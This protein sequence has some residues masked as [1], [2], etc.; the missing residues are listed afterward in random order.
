MKP[1]EGKG[2]EIGLERKN[3][4][5]VILGI[6]ENWGVANL[7]SGYGRHS[8]LAQGLIA[9]P[10]VSY[11]GETIGWQSKGINSAPETRPTSYLSS[12]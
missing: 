4:G 11:T 7:R 8:G 1:N 12:M 10:G 6:G 2:G 5:G 3:I 9:V